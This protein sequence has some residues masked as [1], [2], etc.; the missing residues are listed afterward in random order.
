MLAYIDM[1]DD[2]IDDVALAMREASK[3]IITCEITQAVRDSQLDNL[4]VRQGQ[5][6]SL[7]NGK[8]VAVADDLLQSIRG[9]LQKA[10]ADRYELIT[11]YSGEGLKEDE[12]KKIVDNLSAE[13]PA[14]TLELVHGGQPLYPVVIGI[15]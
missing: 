15:E 9:A 5:Y 7:V 14:S 6:I 10:R 3:T 1:I 13:F 8:L 4:A 12:A 11:I 2:A